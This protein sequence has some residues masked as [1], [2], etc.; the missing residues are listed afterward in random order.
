LCGGDE[1]RHCKAGLIDA[2]ANIDIEPSTEILDLPNDAL[3]AEAEHLPAQVE[4]L[5]KDF[6]FPN[7]P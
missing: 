3:D 6:L 1:C 5:V 2:E 7:I 4:Q